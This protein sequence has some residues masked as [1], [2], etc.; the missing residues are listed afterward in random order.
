M[1]QPTRPPE[2][3]WRRA[4]VVV[5]AVT[6]D[7]L[8]TGLLASPGARAVPSARPLRGAVLVA[9]MEVAGTDGADDR[10]LRRA[11]R[12][13]HGG[14]ATPLLLLADEP[15]RVGCLRAL[16]L[17]DAAGPVRTVEVGALAAAL[18]RL[19]SLPRLE[20]VRELAAELDRLDQAG[21][22]G[23]K[24]RE[25]LTLHTLNVRLR[26]DA[27]RWDRLQEA[28][29]GL[30]RGADWR[31]VLHTLGYEV[32]PRPQRGR[33][34]RLDGRP[35]AVVHPRADP[36]EFARMAEDGRPPEGILLNDC[37]TEGV[38][39]GLLASGSRLRLF[40]AAP[41]TGSAAA[42]YLDLDASVLQDDD[43]PFLG[44]LGPAYLAE[45]QF[46]ALQREARDYGAGL[47]T[48]LDHAIRQ[49]A[50]PALGLALGRWARADGADPADDATREELERAALTLVFRGLFIL[51]AE[52]AGYLP[53]DSR[54]YEESS[55]TRLI[56]EAAD[57]LDD[58]DP[59]STS[60]WDRFTL[61]VKAMRTGNRSR[62]WGVPA[63]NG[64]LFAAD[65]FDG[66]AT[67]ERAE[68][69]DPDFGRVL[70]GIGRPPGGDVGLDYSTLEIG[71]LGNIYEGL[72]SLRLSVA[73]A[74][75]RYDARTDRYGPVDDDGPA[76]VEN[77]DLLWQTNEG[78]RKGGGV[79]YTRSE[80]VR[81]LVRHAVVPAF[82]AHL[83]RVRA[84]AATDPAGAAEELFDFAVLDPAC[85]SA[86]FLV[87]VVSELADRV[88]R[89]LADTPLPAVATSIERLRAG[90]SA[91]AAIDDVALL[92]RLVTKRCVFGVDLSPMGAEVAKLSLW[93][94]SFVPGLSLAYLDRNVQVGNSLVGVVHPEEI[95][96]QGALFEEPL[97]RATEQAVAAVRQVVAGEDR[98]P[99]EVRDSEGAD[100]AARVATAGL[101]RLCDLWTAGAF[102]VAGARQ[103]VHLHGAD[104]VTGA[105]HHRWEEL[106][107]LA[108]RHRFMHW[109]TAFPHVLARD[110]P[111]FD[112]VVGNP[113]WEEVTI[114]ALAFLGLFRPGL[115]S[116]PEGERDQAVAL[117]LAERPALGD[118]LASAQERSAAERAYLS[119]AGY[120]SMPGDPDLYK[121]F[122]AR[123][124]ALLRDGGRLGVVLP[125]SAFSA[126]GSS[127]F[128]TWLFEETSC[129]RLDFLLN[130]GR[131]AFDSEPRYTVA[132][133]A[134][135][136][137]TPAGDHRTAVAGTASSLTA[138]ETQA[139]SPGLALA[140]GAFGPGR[141]VPLLRSQAEA[142]L[143]AKLRRGTPFPRGPGGRWRSFAVA[144]LHETNDRPLW[145]GAEEG[146]PLWKGESFDQYDP[147]GA[148]ARA[149]PITEAVLKKIRKPRPGSFFA[150]ELPARRRA[151]TVLNEL[152]GARVA[153]R[154]VS[155]AT[156]SRT[157]R[158]SLVPP[159][160]L[161]TNK[162]PYLAFVEGGNG[163]RA[164]TL[165]IMNSLAFDW[166]ARRFVEVNLNFFILEGLIVPDLDD[167]A[168]AAIADGAAR[169]SCVD[170]RFA[171]FA[172][173]F[174]IE[175]GPMPDD[176]RERLRVEID[177]RV[178]AAWGLTG[179][180]LDVLLA[181]FTAD[182]VPP[183]YRRQLADRLD[184]LTG[185]RR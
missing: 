23:L 91:G 22:P 24:L 33:L 31:A 44:L 73:D 51:Y 177:A 6:L 14:G 27:L 2:V 114:E 126:S 115:R 101:E 179:G 69:A 12:D 30:P 20:A 89:F 171:A 37:A 108:Q 48:R 54:A 121:Y 32:V 151:E 57:G 67:L 70:V 104:I 185:G 155:R 124:Q 42:R 183:A 76:D 160:V 21:I 78:G 106:A 98:S 119:A 5:A 80:L 103:E 144:E 180:D 110:R 46:A 66:A 136:R 13:R 11:W 39:Y 90:A 120:P 163:A 148:G 64:A 105:R 147:N 85:G 113:P 58:L 138:W 74:P 169:L 45:G 161:L 52:A 122:C 129:H 88:V 97:R 178:A 41:A 182:A 72:L 15:G 81:H 18:G 56:E 102:D 19:A 71:H 75:L 159:G 142:E 117:L 156:D 164:A 111:G 29:K 25:L 50:L 141:T 55:L 94:A 82:E 61:L 175:P 176:E 118:R 100:V 167:H 28:I 123:Y 40:D 35:V 127:G 109:L 145:Q 143:L 92:R 181:D 49:R 3:R 65:G 68:L 128:R 1:S 146:Q 77:G 149:C 152:S 38:A 154:D 26:G 53:M 172:E 166:Q 9:G 83:D 107:P 63:Y 96:A 4:P 7:D 168:L 116:L 10:S 132:L 84:R 112:A 17:V 86:H 131:W 170:E 139:A 16:G 184:E 125:R 43:R 137:A 87:V 79:Y 34:L 95:A 150:K 140:Q 153:F 60:L 59:R 130:S 99:D 36:A 62:A 134:A 157:V 165:G 8:L 174:S 133:V 173:S 135:E 158:A 93:L 162:A 47:R